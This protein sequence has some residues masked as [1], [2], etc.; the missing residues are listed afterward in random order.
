VPDWLSRYSWGTSSVRLL[1]S[2]TTTV[3]ANPKVW[4]DW[5]D[6]Q[7]KQGEG[8]NRDAL[9]HGIMHEPHLQVCGYFGTRVTE[10]SYAAYK[11]NLHDL[12][13]TSFGDPPKAVS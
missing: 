1:V 10:T 2:L 13:G 9:Y 3:I 8:S 5:L 12:R 4:R 7:V 6:R 11:E